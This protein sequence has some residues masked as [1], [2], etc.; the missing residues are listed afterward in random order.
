M[1]LVG[2]YFYYLLRGLR[3]SPG[4]LRF[5]LGSRSR[6]GRRRGGP[7]RRHF[8]FLLHGRVLLLGVLVEGR[9]GQWKREQPRPEHR[10]RLAHEQ[11]HDVLLVV[12][13]GWAKVG[14]A[15]EVVC[16]A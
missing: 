4:P 12:G 5:G 11:V 14:G 7:L 13:L 10:T 15:A 3:C 8:G 16:S 9:V 2:A 6:R 1:R